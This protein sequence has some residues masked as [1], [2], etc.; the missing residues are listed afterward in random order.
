MGCDS[1]ILNISGRTDI[2]AFYTPW[3]IHRLKEGFVDVRNP[4]YPKLVQRIFFKD[5]DAMV[6]CTKNP[7]PILPYLSEIKIPII[8]QVT[9]TPY[10]KDLEPHLP[11]KGK[12]IEGIKKLATIIPKE[13]L[14]VRYD[15]ILINPTYTLDYHIR[16]FQHLCQALD[17]VVSKV[18]VSF[19]DHYKNVENHSSL[20]QL[21]AMTEEDLKIIGTHFSQIAKEHHMTVQTCGEKHNL[22]EYGFIKRDCVDFTTLFQLTGKTHFTEWK[23]RNNS[24]CHCAKMIDIGAYNSCPHHCKYCYANFKEEEIAQNQKLHDPHSSLLLGHIQEEDEIKVLS[25][26]RSH[27]YVE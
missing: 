20:L 5:V 27:F 14:Y 1:M 17:G 4:F 18:I 8:F 25:D 6:F 22:Q 15:P 3:L 19:I 16:S 9:L 23:A 13:F 11:P 21:K 12:I 2:V 7:L 24:Y 26:K 10:H